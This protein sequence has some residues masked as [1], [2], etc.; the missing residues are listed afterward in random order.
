MFICNLY[1]AHIAFFHWHLHGILRLFCLDCRAWILSRN[2]CNSTTRRFMTLT[3]QTS[4]LPSY[5]V[6]KR[7]AFVLFHSF[8]RGRPSEITV[9]QKG[10][11]KRREGL[12]SRALRFGGSLGRKGGCKKRDFGVTEFLGASSL[13]SCVVFSRMCA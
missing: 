4:S 1:C 6:S 9:R 12:A 7:Y 8:E 2:S 3:F 10:V 13:F 11:G 5:L